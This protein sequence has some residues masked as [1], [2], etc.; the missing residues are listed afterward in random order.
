MVVIAASLSSFDLRQN[1]QG[2]VAILKLGTR[3]HRRQVEFS[4]LEVA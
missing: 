2:L 1:S 4:A 3:Q